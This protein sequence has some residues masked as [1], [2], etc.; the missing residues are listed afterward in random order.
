MGYRWAYLCGDAKKLELTL[1]CLPREPLDGLDRF[2]VGWCSHL[3]PRYRSTELEQTLARFAPTWLRDRA[4]VHDLSMLG[5]WLPKGLAAYWSTD[6]A[7]WSLGV[8]LMVPAAFDGPLLY[9]DDDVLVLKDPAPLLAQG[10]FGS[11]GCFRF[12][13]KKIHVVEQLYQAF[14]LEDWRL[15]GSDRL[16]ALY[17]RY[18]LDAGVFY[19]HNTANWENRLHRFARCP[20]IESLTTRNL[21]LRCLDQRFLTMFGIEHGWRQQSIGNGFAP[22]RVFK[23]GHHTFFHYKSSSKLAWMKVIEAYAQNI[24]APRDRADADPQQ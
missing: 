2:T 8:K 9:T 17:D 22:L 15:P 13:Y 6:K 12:G 20:Y 5:R 24:N 1:R 3:D 10:S 14:D 18:A 4:A 23:P 21:E 7:R 11:K 16:S 19:A